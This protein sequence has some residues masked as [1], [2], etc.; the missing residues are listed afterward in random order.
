MPDL[1]KQRLAISGLALAGEPITT[2][3]KASEFNQAE[4]DSSLALRRFPR[5]ANLIYAFLIYNAALSPATKRPELTMQTEIH[6]EG[7]R[8]FQG[9][10]RPLE[11]TKKGGD[12]DVRPGY[13]LPR[14]GSRM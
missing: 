12:K 14:S 4:W 7:K 6:R 10:P 1:N 3:A 13:C 5:N 8:T 2:E 11:V 9:Q